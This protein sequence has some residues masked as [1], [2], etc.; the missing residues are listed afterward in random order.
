MKLEDVPVGGE[1]ILGGGLANSDITLWHLFGVK[2][3]VMSKIGP[4]AS[5]DVYPFGVVAIELP[6]GT[7]WPTR[8][9]Y[10][11]PEDLAPVPPWHTERSQEETGP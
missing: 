8:E 7:N 5:G 2:A 1:V 3:R 9:I 10:M 11:G 6:I 4:E